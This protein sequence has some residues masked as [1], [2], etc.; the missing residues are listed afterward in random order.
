MVAGFERYFQIARCMRDEDTRG[1]RQ[2]EFTQLDYE[3]SFV[4]QEDI[5]KFTEAMFIE[6]VMTLFPEK[7]ISY[8][9]RSRGSLLRSPWKS[10]ATTNRTCGRIRT[11]RT[12]WH[13]RG[14]L[15]FRCSRRPTM[16]PFRPRIILSVL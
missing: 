12:N 9:R 16:A 15:T 4:T 14:S 11:I 3:M 6:M 7:K 5:L 2:P 1:D 8:L 10:T 13:S